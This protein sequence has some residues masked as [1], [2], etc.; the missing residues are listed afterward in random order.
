MTSLARFF[1]SLRNS[2]RKA[3]I[4]FMTAGDPDPQ[5]TREAVRR[6]VLAGASLVE[7]GFPYS[8]P[9]AD[10][11]VIQASYTRALSKKPSMETLLSLCSSMKDDSLI[12][13]V[14]RLGMLSYSLI[15][16]RGP[17]KFV[18]DAASSGLSGLIVPDL[19]V[20][21]SIDLRPLCAKSGMDL[22]LLVTPTTPRE[23][24]LRI[25]EACSGFV[26]CVSITG[27]TGERSELPASLIDQLGWLRDQT[28]LPLCVG[29]GV[30]RP[31]QV[32]MLRPHVDGVIVG[33]AL[34]RHLERIPS[35]GMN[36][37]LDSIEALARSLCSAVNP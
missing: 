8:D 19:P 21:E 17:E 13:P 25:L 30:S 3:F 27:I 14:P 35:D 2:G 34:V 10:G 6:L 23:R 36:A 26:Y 9:I 12:Q 33:S 31:D 28:K 29:F 32:A 1:D 4:P 18:Q 22:I 11:P 20:E 37:A 15:H 5:T 7:L 16:R 24:A